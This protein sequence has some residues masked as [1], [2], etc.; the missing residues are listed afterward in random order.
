MLRRWHLFG[1]L[2]S[3]LVMFLAA[4]C[5]SG[6]SGK[7]SQ[8]TDKG[9]DEQ[10]APEAQQAPARQRKRQAPPANAEPAVAETPLPPDLS[11]WKLPDLKIALTRKNFQ[12]LFGVMVY[13]AKAPG[14]DKRAADLNDLLQQIGRMNDDPQ[15]ILPLPP[16]T[17]PGGTTAAAGTPAGAAGGTAGGNLGGGA[18]LPGVGR[19][20]GRRLGGGMGGGMRRRKK[21][22]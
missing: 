6:D 20:A 10:A 18:G 16:G 14:D 22:E 12:F 3:A 5:G 1:A 11:K 13:A 2:A 4:G 17:F 19:G 21:D 15:V 8:A 9:S 7:T